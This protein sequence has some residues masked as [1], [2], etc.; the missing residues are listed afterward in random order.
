MTA[1]TTTTTTTTTTTKTFKDVSDW[2]PMLPKAPKGLFDQATMTASAFYHYRG[3]SNNNNADNQR[4]TSSKKF[5]FFLD[6]FTKRDALLFLGF[7]TEAIENGAML[8]SLRRKNH[9]NSKKIGSGL[10][11]IEEGWEYHSAAIGRALASVF[12]EDEEHGDDEKYPTTPR[13]T[14]S[15]RN[16][17]MNEIFCNANFLIHFLKH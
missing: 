4:V 15:F 5:A 1:L 6:P 12:L 8:A 11:D 2:R 14:K 3:I 17:S 10:S 7:H 9:N 13:R 16:D